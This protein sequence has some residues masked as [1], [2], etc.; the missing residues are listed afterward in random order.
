MHFTFGKNWTELEDGRKLWG[1]ENGLGTIISPEGDIGSGQL[2]DGVLNGY[3]FA[4]IKKTWE[5]TIT[6]K[7]TYEEVMETAEFDSCGRV[8]YCDG[9]PLTYTEK[10]EDWI[11]MGAGL[12]EDGKLVR[13]SDM[14]FPEDL[15][16]QGQWV[17]IMYDKVHYEYQPEEILLS[18]VPKD[19]LAHLG[20]T[21]A[22][23]QPLPDGR[24]LGIESNGIPFILGPG[25][26]FVYDYN[27][28][29]T[30]YNKYIYSLKQSQL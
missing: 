21:G 12:W 27:P 29:P 24:I 19:G 5:E 1:S 3:G 30:C 11:L 13:Q 4:F 7:K 26:E 22:Y 14:K 20:W 16:F 23:I 10:R 17:E 18:E 15:V 6:R 2:K 8:I 25:E 28:N 9:S